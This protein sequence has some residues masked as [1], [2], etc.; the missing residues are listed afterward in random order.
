MKPSEV[1]VEVRRQLANVDQVFESGLQELSA[2]LEYQ[3]SARQYDLMLLTLRSFASQAL[4]LGQAA[5]RLDGDA[6]EAQRRFGQC[7]EWMDFCWDALEGVSSSSERQ[8]QRLASKMLLE[9][10]LCLILSNQRAICERLWRD[11]R[12]DV[13]ERPDTLFKSER[14]QAAFSLD[15]I[16]AMG[17][18]SLKYDD[19]AY[20]SAGRMTDLPTIGYETMLFALHRGEAQ[21]FQAARSRLLKDFVARARNR[22][23]ALNPWGYGE[24][25]QAACFDVVATALSR[26]ANWRGL[27]VA[28][29]AECC[30]EAFLE[31]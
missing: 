31:D 23:A 1:E 29:E 5:W 25:A 9:P 28:G 20:E 21:A 26:L 18:G 3:R 17:K 19:T 13:F 12:G 7:I 24:V 4:V 8:K 10:S 14:P 22:E 30:P 2:A 27:Q 6:T 16:E 11:S 15:L